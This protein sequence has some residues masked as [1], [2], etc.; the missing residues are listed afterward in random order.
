[1]ASEI[2]NFI[3]EYP[4]DYI[5]R[6]HQFRLITIVKG[7]EFGTPVMKYEEMLKTLD[8]AGMDYGDISQIKAR[9]G[10]RAEWVTL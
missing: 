10:G 8:D 2:A 9:I 1:M 3:R 4:G 5:Q 6:H 7:V